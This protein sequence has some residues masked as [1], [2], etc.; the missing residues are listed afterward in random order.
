LLDKRRDIA[1][2]NFPYDVRVDID[3]IVHNAIA[4]ADD[5]LPGNL[6]T[7]VTQVGANMGCGFAN[8]LDQIGQ[9]NL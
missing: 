9:N 4:H 7:L 1:R 3:V 6:R 5:L 8:R 2:G